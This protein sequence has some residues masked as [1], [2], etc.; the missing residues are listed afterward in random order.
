MPWTLRSIGDLLFIYDGENRPRLMVLSTPMPETTTAQEIVDYLNRDVT[1]ITMVEECLED[2]MAT[3][4]KQR[5]EIANLEE[6]LKC[7]EPKK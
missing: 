3:I 1:D 2:A 7:P 4:E 5:Q 6:D